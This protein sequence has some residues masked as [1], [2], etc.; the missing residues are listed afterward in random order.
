VCFCFKACALSGDADLFF[1]PLVVP[2]NGLQRITNTDV[3]LL[4]CCV[5]H[6]G[7]ECDA[8][9]PAAAVPLQAPDTCAR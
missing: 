8:W 5:M 9:H 4:S 1:A 3:V 2:S 7:F 6:A